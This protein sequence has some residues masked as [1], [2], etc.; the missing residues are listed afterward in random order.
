MQDLAPPHRAT[1]TY[2]FLEREDIEVMEWPGNAPD[3]NPIEN[4]WSWLKNE[5]YINRKKVN[6]KEKLWRFAQKSF[7]SEKCKTLCKTCIASVPE[8]IDTLI[9]KEGGYVKF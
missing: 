8:R 3:M 1:K 6:T 9:K 4:I 7:L 5:I 2:K